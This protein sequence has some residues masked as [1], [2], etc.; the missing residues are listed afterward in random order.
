M[1][2]GQIPVG[3]TVAAPIRKVRIFSSLWS[4]GVS[5]KM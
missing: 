4:H 2:F 5:S 1:S 3:R